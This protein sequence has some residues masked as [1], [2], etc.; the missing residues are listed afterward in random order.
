MPSVDPVVTTEP[1]VDADRLGGPE[2]KLPR[3]AGLFGV[4]GVHLADPAQAEARFCRAAAIARALAIEIVRGPVR[5]GHP[6]DVRKGL[7]DQPEVG[8]G[9]G[10]TVW[11]GSEAQGQPP[12][13]GLSPVGE[14][15]DRAYRYR[16]FPERG[17]IVTTRLHH[18]VSGRADRPTVVLGGSIGST[19]ASWEPQRAALAANFQVLAYDHR[20]HGH[21]PAPAGPYTI[22]ALAADVLAVLDDLDVRQAHWVGLSLGGMVA[23]HVAARSPQRV[24]RLVLACVA[25]HYP[26]RESWIQRAV[27]VRAGGTRA[28]ADVTLERWLTAD[29]R[30]DHPE[31]TARLRKMI[32]DVDREG[33]AGCC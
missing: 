30:R 22:E 25:P 2:G 33:Y 5:T 19:S 9:E 31:E 18:H 1:I 13:G 23:Q 11:S 4:V 29:Y 12:N 8:I 10:R 24:D 26:D 27:T 14:D 20:G 16:A 3:E 21:S 17:E 7:H 6:H 32:V 15:G 28:I